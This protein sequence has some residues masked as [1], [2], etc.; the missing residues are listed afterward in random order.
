MQHPEK[1]KINKETS[2]L[3]SQ[4]KKIKLTINLIT[5]EG[6]SKFEH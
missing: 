5:V 3:F 4:V 1:R 2:S 6:I